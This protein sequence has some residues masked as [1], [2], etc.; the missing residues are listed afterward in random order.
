MT[1]NHNIELVKTKTEFKLTYRDG[2]FKKLEHLRGVCDAKIL[3]HIGLVIPPQETDLNAFMESMEG[4]AIYTTQVKGE[5][6]LYSKFNEAW[7]AFFKKE[8]QNRKPKFT[9][10]DGKAL[11]QIISYLKEENNNDEAAALSVWNFI[12]EN[13]KHLPEFF[14]NNQDLKIINSKLNVIITALQHK[15]TS[16]ERTF[17]TA[18]GSE[19]ARAFKFGKNG[20]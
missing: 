6:T 2:K 18:A 12:L 1:T 5:K 7:F 4:R 13:W 3:K 19:A 20:N 11:N 15:H 16:N 8:N 17:Q 9:G 14:K 10:A